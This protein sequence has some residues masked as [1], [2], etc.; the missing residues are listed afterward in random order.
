[1]QY[2]QQ[3]HTIYLIGCFAY[4]PATDAFPIDGVPFHFLRTFIDDSGGEA[5]FEGLNTD[6]VKDCFIKPQTQA[7]KL[8]LCAQMK[9]A[10]DARIQP[11]TWF[12]SHAWKYKS[13]WT[14]FKAL[15]ACFAGKGGAIIYSFSASQNPSFSKPP[16]W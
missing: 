8:S 14:L 3:T 6:D 9:Q 16:Q 4:S 5:A 10:G 15:E 7:T 11:A 12:V 2:F 13:F 1:L